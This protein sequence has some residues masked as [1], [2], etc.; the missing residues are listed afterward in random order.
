MNKPEK[1]GTLDA[2]VVAGGVTAPFVPPVSVQKP[3]VTAEIDA[4]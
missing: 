1:Q 4:L 2:W 3:D